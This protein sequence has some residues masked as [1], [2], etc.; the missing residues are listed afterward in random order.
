[1]A[2]AVLVAV[3]ETKN[4]TENETGIGGVTA[5]DLPTLKRVNFGYS[6]PRPR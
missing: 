5:P 2:A 4:E 6:N 3:A 1:M